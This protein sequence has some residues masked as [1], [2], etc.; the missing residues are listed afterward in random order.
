MTSAA[1]KKLV[2]L[3]RRPLSTRQAGRSV[4]RLQSHPLSP[5]A[6]AGGDKASDGLRG[7]GSSTLGADLQASLSCLWRRGDLC[8]LQIR[9]E[10]DNCSGFASALG[11]DKN[12]YFVLSLSGCTLGDSSQSRSFYL[13][14]SELAPSSFLFVSCC[15]PCVVLAPL[16]AARRRP[17]ALASPFA[18][19]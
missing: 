7:A 8:C 18:L 4:P 5:A 1:V 13:P 6:A 3:T 9:R 10:F 16:P 14:R 17:A 12:Q 15:S 19:A 11:L 2:V